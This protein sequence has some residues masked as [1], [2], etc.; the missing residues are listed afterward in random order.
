MR[1]ELLS[2]HSGLIKV[3][4]D[5]TIIPIFLIKWFILREENLVD[6]SATASNSRQGTSPH[7]GKAKLLL[8]RCSKS[9]FLTRLASDLRL[10]IEQGL[11]LIGIN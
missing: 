1:V 10:H 6:N 11:S 9:K 7:V 8:F 4:V 2:K 5:K 3:I